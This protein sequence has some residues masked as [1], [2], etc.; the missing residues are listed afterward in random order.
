L[1]SFISSSTAPLVF[2]TGVVVTHPPRLT[3]QIAVNS[4]AVM[5]PLT[6]KVLG[7]L[8]FPA[9]DDAKHGCDDLKDCTQHKMLF[10][11]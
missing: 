2:V 4:L 5:P 8:I 10:D 3:T 6:L 9:W 11:I 7:A 1:G